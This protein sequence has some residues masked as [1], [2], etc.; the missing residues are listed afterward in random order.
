VKTVKFCPICKSEQLE[1]L[2]RR[3]KY[4]GSDVHANIL[5]IDYVRN[6]ILFDRILHNR[7]PVDFSF[8]IDKN[9]GFI[10]FS[11][12]PEESDMVIKYNIVNIV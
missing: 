11:P 5:N 8:K 6:Y 10:F 12:R 3:V 9:C 2:F 1:E 4:Y 7:N